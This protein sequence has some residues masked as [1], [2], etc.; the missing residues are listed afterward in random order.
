[1]IERRYGMTQRRSLARGPGVQPLPRARE[2]NQPAR[3][4]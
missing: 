2:W 1:M 3:Q 4:P